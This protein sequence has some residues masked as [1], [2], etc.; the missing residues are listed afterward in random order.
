MI[1]KN[2]LNEQIKKGIDL[3]EENKFEE[4]IEIFNKLEEENDN[5]IK[6]I[7]LFFLGIIETKKKNNKSAKEFFLKTLNINEDHE[8]ANLNIGSLLIQEKNF[9]KSLYYFEKVLSNNEKNLTALYH[10][11]LVNFKLKKFDVSIEFLNKCKEV[12][13]NFIHSYILLG[14]IYLRIKEFDKAIDNYKKVLNID[15]K[16]ISTRFNLSWC[17]FAKLE[18]DKAFENYEFRKEKIEP[19]NRYKEVK[20]KFGDIEW[21]GQNLSN[22]KILIISEQGYGD[23]INFFRYLFWLNEKF[24][25]KIIFYAQKKIDHLFQYTPFKIISSLSLIGRIDYYKQLLSLPGLYYEENKSFQKNIPYIKSNPI[26]DLKWQKKL[27]HLKKPIIAINWQGDNTYA[28]DDTRSIPLSYYKDIITNDKFDVISL[29]KNFGSEQIQ[30]N[31]FE[32][33]LLNLSN[34]IDLT[35]NAFEDTIS[36]LKKIN[37][38]ITSDTALAHLAGT[39]NIKTYLMLSYNPEWRWYIEK[40][41][42]CF[43]PNMKIFQQKTF[44]DWKNIFHELNIELNKIY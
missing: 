24:K 33:L 42:K 31:K 8:E 5:E 1:S 35:N 39:M 25:T 41:Y 14:H 12:N 10:S 2:L 22:K 18:L 23:N 40:H 37:C 6:I 27:N 26:L 32:S 3:F 9:E 17:Y 11:G 38:F 44:G 19:K 16:R 13:E 36:I 7:G 21:M 43:Y 34:E 29:Q 28:H 4:A 15:P 30:S 20:D